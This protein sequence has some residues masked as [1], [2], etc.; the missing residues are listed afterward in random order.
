MTQEISKRFALAVC[1]MAVLSAALFIVGCN[2]NP[3]QP[4]TV[5]TVGCSVYGTAASPVDVTVRTDVEGSKTYNAITMPWEYY[6]FTYENSFSVQ[7]T[8]AA[9]ASTTSATTSN[10]IPDPYGFGKFAVIDAGAN[11]TA[12]AARDDIITNNDTGESS[13][14]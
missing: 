3:V 5:K 8:A 6:Q 10:S 1:F 13:K 9:A 12:T 4:I 11:F 14:I 7:V 2:M